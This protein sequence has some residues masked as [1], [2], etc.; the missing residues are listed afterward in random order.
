M[1]AHA[2]AYPTTYAPRPARPASRPYAP[3]PDDDGADWL[4]LDDHEAYLPGLDGTDFD[5]DE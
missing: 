1:S 3:I 4:P 2:P 5:T